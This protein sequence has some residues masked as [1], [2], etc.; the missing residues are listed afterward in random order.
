M[1]GMPCSC[2]NPKCLYILL[3][4]SWQHH[5]VHWRSTSIN[6]TW[7]GDEIV[8]DWVGG[9][10]WRWRTQSKVGNCSYRLGLSDFKGAMK[11][12]VPRRRW[13]DARQMTIER[14]PLAL[15]IHWHSWNRFNRPERDPEHGRLK[16][17][18][19]LPVYVTS[20]WAIIV[21]ER[22]RRWS[23]QKGQRDDLRTGEICRHGGLIEECQ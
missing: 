1:V 5:H 15:E 6:E 13:L 7:R 21:R 17:K 14:R 2:D 20:L 23:S 16:E 19:R 10:W 12:W 22:W 18:Q 8:I 9:Q 3:N 4:V 11:S